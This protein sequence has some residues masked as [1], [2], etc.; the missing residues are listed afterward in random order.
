MKNILIIVLL[1]S[2]GFIIYFFI[3]EQF[4]GSILTHNENIFLSVL[5][6][7]VGISVLLLVR[8]RS[9]EKDK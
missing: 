8:K 9:S 6:L 1:I 2:M 7:V 5:Y 4:N 3:K